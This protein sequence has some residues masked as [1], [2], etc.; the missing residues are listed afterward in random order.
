M[1]SQKKVVPAAKPRVPATKMSPLRR[2]NRQALLDAASALM[3]EGMVPTIADAA[4]RA[5]ISR[6]T[7]YRYFSSPEQLQNEAALDAIARRIADMDIKERPGLSVQDAVADLIGKVHQMSL[8]HEVAFRTMLRLS[9]DPEGSGR[10]GRRMGWIAGLLERA[11]LPPRFATAWWPRSPSCAGSKR[12]SCSTMCAPCRIAMPGRRSNGPR[13]RW[14]VP[15]LPKRIAEAGVS[16]RLQGFG[17]QKV[18]CKGFERHH[19]V[20]MVCPWK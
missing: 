19:A 3:D 17:R 10:G 11:E 7:A 4:D 1:P 12:I 20:C 18:R 13:A 15:L 6:A 5:E 16:G 9:L 2:R 14:Y 8:D